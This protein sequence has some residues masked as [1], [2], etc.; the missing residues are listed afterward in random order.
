MNTKIS[1]WKRAAHAVLLILVFASCSRIDEIDINDFDGMGSEALQG[2]V[3]VFGNVTTEMRQHSVTLTPVKQWNESQAPLPDINRVFVL[4]GNDTILYTEQPIGEF[5]PNTHSKTFV[6]EQ[7]FKGEVGKTYRL[8]IETPAGDITAEDELLALGNTDY[9]Q[10]MKD[11]V[12]CRI[13]QTPSGRTKYDIQFPKHIYTLSEQPA[14]SGVTF[15]SPENI[16]IDSLYFW[17]FVHSDLSLQA[18]FSE[19]SFAN[20]YDLSDLS[21]EEDFITCSVSP[22]FYSFLLNVFNESDWSMGL[23]AS[24]SGNAQGNVKNGYGY[25]FASDV[26]RKRFAFNELTDENE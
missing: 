20:S 25:F 6:S 13:Y 14:I 8:V 26:Q 15:Y 21:R 2:R 9:F 1:I 3:A 22:S 7:P 10:L 5:A 11:N 17:T 4:C 16:P 24:I 19:Q 12:H 18:L 23:F